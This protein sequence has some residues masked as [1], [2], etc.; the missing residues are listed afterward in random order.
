MQMNPND[1]V[2]AVVY[3]RAVITSGDRA[4]A[5]A[6]WQQWTNE[7]PN[8]AQGFTILGTLQEAQGDRD[9]AIAAYKK[10]IQIQPD[11]PVASNNLS[12]LMIE[13]GQNIDV[14]LSL[15]Q[16]A[17]RGMPDSPSTADTLAWAY[18]HKGNYTSARDLLEDAVKASPN[19]A[20]L[21]YHLGL[22]YNKLSDNSDATLHLK[23]AVSLAPN[24][25]TAKDAEKALN[26][27]S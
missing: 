17:R 23:K 21:H 25:Q 26:Q 15:A 8:D 12:Y 19:D 22:T 13:T 10:A 24:S 14:A 3:T 9:Q 27:L 16:V 2:A 4:K 6:K 20:A 7:H 1:P 18:Y 11:Q 5:L